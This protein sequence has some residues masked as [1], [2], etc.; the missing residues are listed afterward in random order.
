[1]PIA[2]VLT[3][4]PADNVT[5][6][7]FLGRAVHAWFLEQVQDVNPALAQALHTANVR[8]PF[9]VSSLWWPGAYDH[10]DYTR[11]SAG[12][13]GYLRITSVAERLTTLL[14]TE[15]VPKWRE[16]KVLLGGVLFQVR[17]VAETAAAHP[18][19]ATLSYAA[20]QK[21]ATSPPPSPHVT[22]RFL[23]PTTFRHSAPRDSRF[24]TRTHNLPFPQP[25]L[26]FGNLLTT[27]QTFAPWPLPENVPAFVRDCVIL[28]RYNLHTEKVTFG[29]GRRGTV[30]GFVGTCRFV[31]TCSDAPLQQ[32]VSI[33]GAFAPFAGVGWR[34]TMGL[35]QVAYLDGSHT[36][37]KSET[38]AR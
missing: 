28:N 12:Q 11:L 14:K 36:G 38:A 31:I 9:T 24:T 32:A 33:L 35:G 2:I 13:R 20:L 1:M 23:T 5:L 37:P 16:G 7:A 21:K 8:R 15:L 30:G 34:T 4:T 18:R 29:N 6:P 27:W 25:E 19:A 17:A 10:K 26:V 22:L 3:L